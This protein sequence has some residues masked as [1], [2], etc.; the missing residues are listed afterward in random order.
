MKQKF[1]VEGMSCNNC[2]AHVEKEIMKID[3]IEDFNVDL[4]TGELSVSGYN[5]T[6][7][8]IKDAVEKAGYIFKDAV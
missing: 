2:K 7:D 3:E 4:A 8:Q 5:F 6:S 1:K